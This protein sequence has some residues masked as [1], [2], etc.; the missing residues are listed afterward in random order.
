[1]A[2]RSANANISTSRRDG[3]VAAAQPDCDH[4]TRNRSR[5][6][7]A[8]QSEPEELFTSDNRDRVASYS[9][10][11]STRLRRGGSR[12]M[13]PPAAIRVRKRAARQTFRC[14]R[15]IS[16]RRFSY[17]HGEVEAPAADGSGEKLAAG[18]SRRRS[19][20]FTPLRKGEWGGVV[21]GFDPAMVRDTTIYF[22]ELSTCD[23]DTPAWPTCDAQIWPTTFRCIVQF[24][25]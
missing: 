7:G 14:R 24:P 22:A 20:R 2:A 17:R 9:S 5:F 3:S 11:P 16:P 23:F 1:M 8:H 13:A 21:I 6:G 12:R 18:G 4:G 25:V 10:A 15:W 19:R